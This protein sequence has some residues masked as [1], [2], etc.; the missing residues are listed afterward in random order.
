MVTKKNGFLEMPF[1]WMFALLAGAVILFLAIFFVVKLTSTEELEQGIVT[2]NQVGIL[3]SPLEIGFESAKTTVLE[4]PSNS[5]IYTICDSSGVFGKQ[6]IQVSQENF[7]KISE[8]GLNASFQNKYIFSENPIE[9]RNFYIFT[10]PFIFPFKV[11]DLVYLIPS[12]NVYCFVNPPN[13]TRKEISD[14]KIKS[15]INVS[16]KSNCTLGS[17]SVCF[18]PG[19]CNITVNK[20]SNDINQNYV[21]RNNKRLYFVDDSLMYAAIFG[22]PNQYDCQIERIAK[23]T[24]ELAKLYD[25][26]QSLVSARGCPTNINFNELFGFVDYQYFTNEHIQEVN[27]IKELNEQVDCQLW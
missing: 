3:L 8:G 14:L 12:T 16:S 20:N 18:S 10:K 11:S 15:V 7:G 17:I 5:R 24:V 9:G 19:N 22:D 13:E 4:L 6:K 23:R 27:R 25:R 1:G 21:N 26:K 2:S